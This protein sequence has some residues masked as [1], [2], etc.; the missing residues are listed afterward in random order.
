[1]GSKHMVLVDSIIAWM[2]SNPGQPLTKCA[3]ALQLSTQWIRMVASTDFFKA[4]LASKQD[5]ILTQVGIMGLKEKIAAAAEAAVERL[6]EKISIADNLDS[7]VGAADMLLEKHYALESGRGL[8]GGG[9]VNVNMT[10][11][12]QGREQMLQGPDP[13]TIEVQV[14]EGDKK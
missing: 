3:A 9:V 6:A 14:E 1:M 8:R 5:D 12:L 7:I 11:I 10:A 13:A 4:R 2:I